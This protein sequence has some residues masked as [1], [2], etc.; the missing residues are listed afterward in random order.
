MLIRL[1]FC[2]ALMVPAGASAQSLVPGPTDPRLVVRVE[3]AQEPVLRAASPR[4][5]AIIGGAAGAAVGLF[6][7]VAA[8][9]GTRLGAREYAVIVV[10]AVLGALIGAALGSAR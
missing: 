10:P 4:R 7:L 8:D 3:A 1:L 6:L 9:E 2:L 5:G